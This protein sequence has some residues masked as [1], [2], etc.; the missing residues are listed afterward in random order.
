MIRRAKQLLQNANISFNPQTQTE[1]DLRGLWETY[2]LSSPEGTTA[3]E[4]KLIQFAEFSSIVYSL[5][6]SR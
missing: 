6:G 5:K 1:S 3:R 4:A 2:V